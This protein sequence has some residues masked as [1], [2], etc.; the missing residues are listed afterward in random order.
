MAIRPDDLHHTIMGL[1]AFVEPKMQI[2]DFIKYLDIVFY[3][4]DVGYDNPE[5]LTKKSDLFCLVSY[6]LTYFRRM[7]VLTIYSASQC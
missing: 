2:G 1:L 6:K 5:R 3:G 7:F 4:M